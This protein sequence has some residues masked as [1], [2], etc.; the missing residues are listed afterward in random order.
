VYPEIAEIGP[1]TIHS[2]GVM[3]ALAFMTAGLMTRWGLKKRGV[4]P[5]LTYSLLIA[6]VVGGVVGAKIHFLILNPGAG[7]FFSGNGLV[8]YGGL[9][10]G[11]IAVAAVA[12]FS[13]PP[14]AVVADAVAPGLALGYA[15]GRVGCLLRGDDYGVPTGLP[16][17]MSFP[18]G[19][20][21]TTETVH[22]TQIYESLGSLAILAILLWVLG[23]RFKRSGSLFWAYLVFAGIERFLVEFV[24][25]NDPAS[26]GLT[27]AQW[28]SVILFVAGVI[29]VWWLEIKGNGSP[30]P[31]GLAGVSEG[32][33][34]ARRRPAL[35]GAAGGGAPGRSSSG[36]P[37][38]RSGK[39]KKRSNK[40]RH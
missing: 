12:Y 7:G 6:A 17:G 8:W 15:V 32:R 14:T 35:Q 33:V 29:G 34:S 10:G 40:A 1:I 38:S 31:Y 39:K 37:R 9:I 22:P 23:P 13:R 2:F 36:A 27:H 5:E 30:S 4:D 3:M 25:T 28:I 18:E 24:R 19:L 26:L 16:W 20:P 21:P 11:I